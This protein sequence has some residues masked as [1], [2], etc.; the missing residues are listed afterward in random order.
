MIPD[1]LW[2]PGPWSGKLAITARPRGGDWLDAE[3]VGWRSAGLDVVVSLLEE[4][5]AAQLELALEGQAAAS[6]GARFVSFPIPDHGVPA[7]TQRV[8]ALLRDIAG[9]LDDGKNVAVHCRQG[10]GR[11][12]LI[13]AGALV[14]AG[15]APD[16]AIEV[17]SA[18]R[19]Q[20]VPET[21]AQH[22]WIHHLPSERLAEAI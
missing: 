20:T 8:I 7:S 13:A 6:N 2:I 17:V 16:Q 22:R 1:L 14:S 21:A 4:E 3:V 9:A 18:A 11:S 5:E 19:G 10:I 15:M 12:G